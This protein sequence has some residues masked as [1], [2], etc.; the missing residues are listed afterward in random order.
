ML[1]RMRLGLRI[2]LVTLASAFACGPSTPADDTSGDTSSA[3]ATS[4]TSDGG[5]PTTAGPGDTNMPDDDGP[6]D[7]TT[8]GT[9]ATVSTDDTTDDDDTGPSGADG[10]T[11]LLII[12]TPHG[13]YEDQVWTG[14]GEDFELGPVLEPLSAWSDALVLVDGVENVIHL[15]EGAELTN[16]YGV[17]SSSILTGGLLGSATGESPWV[18]YSGG[19][20]SLDVVLG[21]AL[22]S[23]TPHTNVHLGVLAT[24]I[25]GIPTGVSYTGAD[26]PLLPIDSPTLAFA[27]LFEG[28]DDPLLDPVAE[29]VDAPIEGPV[30]TLEVQLMIAAAAI[31]LDVTRVQLLSIDRGLPSIMWSEL[32]IF[33]GYHEVV[34]NDDHA[35][36]QMVQ[37]MWA[38]QIAGL[39]LTLDATPDGAGTLLDRTLVVWM[40]AEGSPPNGYSTNDVFIVLVDKSGT[41]ATGRIADV[42]G[43]QA[44]FA[45]T[46][47]AALSA[48]LRDFG[49]PDLDATVIDE[50]LAR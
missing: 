7:A 23:R 10:P 24:D 9:D 31:Q 22:G 36:V 19:G 2:A 46:I 35:S 34:A 40:S 29:R 45:A 17:T 12:R 28:I 1:A 37:T 15:P 38:E 26:Q 47:A 14:S 8:L 39:L 42:E 18:Y 5:P 44:D 43:D 33:Q 20:P 32:G 6:A 13:V 41:F 27:S 49:H 4:E 21:D 48:P 16:M 3:G 11:H 30:E 25:A 50:L